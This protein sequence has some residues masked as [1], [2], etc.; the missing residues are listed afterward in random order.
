MVLVAVGFA[1]ACRIAGRGRPYLPILI[2]LASTVVLHVGDLVAG[3]RLELNTV[4]GYSPTVGIRV[5]GEGNLTFAQLGAAAVLLAAL[6]VW[7]VPT[8]R[9]VYAV[10]G[11]LAVTLTVMAAPPF[12]DDFGAALAAFPAFALLAWLLLGRR[13]RVRTLALLS[14]GVVTVALLVGFVD[15]LRP[16]DQRTHIGRFFSQVGRDGFSGLSKVLRRKLDANLASFS[17]ARLM[18]VLPIVGALVVIVWLSDRTRTR[19]L[20]RETPVLRHGLV[21]LAV[22]MVLGY[23]LNDSGISIPALMAVVFESVVVYVALQETTAGSEAEERPAHVPL[24]R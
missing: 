13:V 16:P 7:R 15:L 2:A 18:W 19:R 3:V 23:A 5:A 20:V 24:R 9:A 21:V 1:A 4:F 11:M 6:V 10:V 22:L 12:G 14:V 17:S 8:R